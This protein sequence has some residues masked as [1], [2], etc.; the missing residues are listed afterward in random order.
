MSRSRVR[1]GAA[2]AAVVLLPAGL[3]V[4]ALG[5]TAAAVPGAQVVTADHGTSPSLTKLARAMAAVAAPAAPATTWGERGAAVP[6]RGHDRDGAVSSR[7]GPGITAMPPATTFPGLTGTAKPPDPVGDIGPNHY[8]EMVNLSVGV[9]KRDGTPLL[10]VPLGAI[11][12]GLPGVHPCEGSFG[13]PIVLHDQLA[14]RWLLTQFTA[15]VAPFYLCMAVSQ[16]ADPTGAYHLYAFSNGALF[17]DY[18]KYGVWSGGYLGSTRDFNGLGG[19]FVGVGTWAFERSKMLVGDPTAVGV[20]VLLAPGAEPWKPGD[21]LLP[22]DLDGKV[23]PPFANVGY[24]I[25]TMDSGASYGAP[26]DGVNVFHLRFSFAPP[27]AALTLVRSIPVAPFDSVFPC[28][29]TSRDCIPQPGTTQKID[30]LSYRQRPMHR[31]AYRRFSGYE[32]L[33]TN[34]SV[35]A[36][37]GVA[38]VRWYELRNL[39]NTTAAPSVF[40]QG[41]VAANDGVHRW[42]GS[43]AQDRR[44]NMALGYSVSNATTVFPGIRYTGRLATDPL[45][46]MPQGEAVLFPGTGSQLGSPRWGDYT[47]MNIDPRDD[48][49]F[50][51]VNEYYA[52][53]GGT[54]NTRVGHFIFPPLCPIAIPGPDPTPAPTMTAIP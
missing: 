50:W 53:T 5:G 6:G 19:A 23:L 2:A 16:T 17:P 12:A 31:A 28:A 44:G 52:V 32:S 14:D 41:T 4:T 1:L 20:K 21:G 38:G 51:Y 30:I 33:V 36:L 3:V 29:P 54:W 45:G 35:E 22:A 8:V 37:P 27:A 24:F 43:I 13:D 7:T 49:R 15:S 9:F 26:F 39:A 46:T 34:Q 42:M 18:P 25:G 11:F 48:C 10:N 47:S 40:Q